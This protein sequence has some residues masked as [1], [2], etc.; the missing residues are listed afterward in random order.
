MKN[1]TVAAT[2][3]A[4]SWNINENIDRAEKLIRQ[5]V[6]SDAQVVLIQELFEAPYFCIEQ[7]F[8][9][10]KMAST[11]DDSK[12]IKRFSKLASEL[13]VVLPV[14][15]YER[16]GSAFFNS[17]AM[18]DANGEIMGVYRKTHIPNSIG[19][20]EKTYFSPG[21]TGFKVWD[22]AYGKIG[23]G[24]CWD[25]WFP[26]AARC[27]ALQGAEL[28]M[29]PTAI[30]SEP[31]V[32]SLDSRNHWQN[33]MCGHAGANIMPL[34][35]SNRIGTEKA[36]NSEMEVTFYGSSFIADQNG[37]KVEVANRTDET[38]LL[39]S[40]DLDVIREHRESWGVYRDRRPDQYKAIMTIDGHVL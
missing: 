21:D 12:T 28:L 8:K 38:V 26:E 7:D 13:S 33:V 40:F 4:C 22:T 30:G 9:H 18:I 32:A 37:D 6:A 5:A 1:L 34:V 25:Q 31:G 27:M 10:Q 11:I 17:V 15:W 3:M 2:Q 23:V 14:S 16:S 24:I 36:T 19:Y 39:R 29:Y 35:A 20:Q